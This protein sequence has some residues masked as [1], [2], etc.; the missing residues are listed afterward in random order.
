MWLSGLLIVGSLLAVVVGD[1]LVT[2]GQVRL[3]TTQQALVSALAT[4]K[5][6]QTDVAEKAAPPV[7]VSHAKSQGLVAASQVVYLPQVPLDVPLPPPRLVPTS[8]GPAA[9]SAASPA[10]NA[11]ASAPA[12][13]TATTTPSAATTTAGR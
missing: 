6:L 12:A 8:S 13:Q 11:T 1:A 3:S 4:Q 2:Q 9:P 10:S 7:V 5:G